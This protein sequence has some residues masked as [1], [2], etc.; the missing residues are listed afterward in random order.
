[1]DTV[2]LQLYK[3]GSPAYTVTVSLYAAGTDD[4]PTGSALTSTTFAASSLTTAAAW[5]EYQF[6]TGYAVT[7]GTKYALVLSATGGDTS[8]IAYWRVNT[9]GTYSGGMKASSTDNGVN[10][11]TNSAQD[12]MFKEGGSQ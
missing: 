5:Y 12:F 10:W 6:S 1:M 11:T 4:K 2:S 8:N 7:A 3:L 9:A